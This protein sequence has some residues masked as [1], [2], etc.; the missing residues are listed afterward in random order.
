MLQLDCFV[1]LFIHLYFRRF[2]GRLLHGLV[3]WKHSCVSHCPPCN[4]YSCVYG[5]LEP[6][7]TT[8]RAFYIQL[9]AQHLLNLLGMLTLIWP[10]PRGVGIATFSSLQVRKYRLRYGVPRD[11]S[12]HDERNDEEAATKT[13]I[14]ILVLVRLYIRVGSCC[15]LVSWGM[16]LS[17]LGMYDGRW[18]L[19]HSP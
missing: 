9:Y 19:H 18:F 7:I 5:E 3:Y 1:E 13:E 12:K 11:G 15:V 10:D 2:T 14:R 17:G 6:S 8:R 4:T 16:S